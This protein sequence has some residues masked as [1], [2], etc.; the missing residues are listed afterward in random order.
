MGQA[1][2]VYGTKTKEL[3]GLVMKILFKKIKIK[4]DINLLNI[5]VCCF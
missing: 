4:N 2:K 5:I 3:D 1:V